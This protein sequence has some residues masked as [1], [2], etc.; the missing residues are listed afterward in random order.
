MRRKDTRIKAQ[1]TRRSEKVISKS[2]KP[3]LCSKTQQNCLLA[4]RKAEIL[5]AFNTGSLYC[6]LMHNKRVHYERTTDQTGPIGTRKHPCILQLTLVVFLPFFV[7]FS[8]QS[9][10]NYRLKCHIPSFFP[11]C[12]SFTFYCFVRTHR[13]G[14]INVS[15]NAG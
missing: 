13:V 2:A 12:V 3:K 9:S 14:Y 1:K 6:P 10:S 11:L 5:Y 15:L 4:P 7:V 8:S